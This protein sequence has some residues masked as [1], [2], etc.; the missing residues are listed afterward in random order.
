MCFVFLYVCEL[1]FERLYIS[2]SACVS[3][4]VF[5]CV[6]I[7]VFV[8]TCV[9]VPGEMHV[10]L[11]NQ[12]MLDLGY[13]DDGPYE[14]ADEKQLNAALIPLPYHSYLGMTYLSHTHSVEEMHEPC[15]SLTGTPTLFPAEP[16]PLITGT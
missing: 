16:R 12:T 4:R 8:V 10:Q 2:V 15:P 1:F 14:V 6:R 7:C 3:L 5:L 13:Y 9:Y 11:L